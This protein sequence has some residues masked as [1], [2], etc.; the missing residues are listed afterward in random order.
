MASILLVQ[1]DTRPQIQVTISRSNSTE[2]V[3][4]RTASTVLRFRK[5]DTT[6]VLT[7]LTAITADPDS[8][9]EG[10][11]VFQFG[12]GDLDIDP[13]DYEG[14]VEVTYADGAKETVFEVIKFIV[15]EDFG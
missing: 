6:T 15:R 1:G 11:C 13:G 9:A 8:L 3:D 10:I 7:T 14:E 12:D 4:L 2:V 5:E